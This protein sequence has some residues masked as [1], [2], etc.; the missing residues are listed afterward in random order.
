MRQ[1]L[2]CDV[3]LIKAA[4]F[5]PPPN[6]GAGGTTWR[7]HSVVLLSQ[8]VHAETSFTVAA[9]SALQLRHVAAPYL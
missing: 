4:T 8:D 7:P 5:K 2:V 1:V 9:P 3:K 6:D